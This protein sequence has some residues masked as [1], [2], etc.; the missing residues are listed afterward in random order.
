MLLLRLQCHQ[1][2]DIDHADLQ[3]RARAAQ[4]IDRGKRL[5]RRNIAGAGHDD[6]GLG[7]AGSVPAHSQMP[8]P[9][10]QW[11]IGL[12]MASH[13]GEGCLPA[14]ITLMRS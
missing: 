1:V 4:E 11:V 6:V 3:I 13:C 10:S 5:Q 7:A 12:R 14:T 9:A 8:I 2:D